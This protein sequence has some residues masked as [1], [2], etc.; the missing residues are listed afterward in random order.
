MPRYN[1]Y[2]ASEIS[3]DTEAG[4]GSEFAVKT[5]EKLAAK[6]LPPDISYEWTDLSYQQTTTGNAGL[7]VF[8][9]C[10]AFVYLVLAALYG[11]WT[12]PISILLIVPMCLLAATAGVRIMGLDMSV[13]TQVGFIVLIGLAAKNA[14]LIVEFARHLGN[15]RRRAD[16]R[17][18]RS[19]PSPA[20]PYP[21]DVLRVHLGRVPADYQRWR[22]LG[23]AQGGRH[24][25][26]SSG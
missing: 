11:S 18:D 21:D 17:R 19:L 23:N 24:H 4:K 1:L 22:R 25:R 16:H 12:L 6:V 15:E 14:I 2:P 20:P 13:L 9:L 5:M 10:V 8:P 7:L 26:C 3:G